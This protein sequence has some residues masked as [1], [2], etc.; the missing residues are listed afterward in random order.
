LDVTQSDI[1]Y[2]PSDDDPSDE[3]SL[4]DDKEVSSKAG[5][6][7]DE[8]QD[9]TKHHPAWSDGESS[10]QRAGGGSKET[11]FLGFFGNFF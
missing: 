9:G 6:K 5:S 11:P 3:E 1:D 10:Y 7:S 4:D 8:K 2:V